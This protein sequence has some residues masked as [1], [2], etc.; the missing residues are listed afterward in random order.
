ML[1]EEEIGGEEVKE[2]EREE[3]EA[4]CCLWKLQSSR[5]LALRHG[6]PLAGDLGYCIALVPFR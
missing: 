5:E 4:F 1:C 6:A 3:W 2:R